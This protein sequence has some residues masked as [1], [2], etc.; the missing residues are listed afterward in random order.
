[1]NIG[2]TDHM[3]PFLT[4]PVKMIRRARS[5]RLAST[6]KKRV[7]ES[8]WFPR[9]RLRELQFSAVNLPYKNVRSVLNQ[10]RTNRIWD[11]FMSINQKS[12][13]LKVLFGEKS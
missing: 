1:M 4:N 7:L 2:W 6:L 8:Q 5:R 3:L 13:I 10:T 9:D 12:D 11:A